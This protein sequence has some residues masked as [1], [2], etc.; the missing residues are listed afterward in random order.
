[1][2]LPIV[3]LVRC[4][5]SGAIQCAEEAW[6]GRILLLE[7]AAKLLRFRQPASHF[8]T[9]KWGQSFR[10]RYCDNEQSKKN[11]NALSRSFLET[12]RKAVTDLRSDSNARALIVKSNVPGTF[13]AGADLKERKQMTEDEVC[14][15]VEGLRAFMT[16][17]SA[18]PVPVIACMDGF[19]LGGGLEMAL[20]CDIRIASPRS[21]MGLVETTLAIFPGAGGTQRLSRVV[22]LAKAKEMIFT[23]RILEASEAL[24]IGLLNH[25]V[26]DP[27]EKS[28]QIAEEIVSKTGP[29]AVRLAKSAI[30]QGIQVSLSSGLAIETAFYAQVTRTKDRME[31]LKAFAEKR[32]PVYKGE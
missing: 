24:N 18:V 16:E 20:A 8:R 10:N 12:F 11:R 28:M 30:D 27:M 4:W 29:L 6:A 31:G 9:S 3:F 21:K 32:K 15:F 25:V 26:E 19:A 14:L 13:C 23:G 7:A 1:M 22:G 17:L 2:W 5:E